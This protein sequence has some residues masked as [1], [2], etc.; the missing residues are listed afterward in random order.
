MGRISKAITLKHQANLGEEIEE[1]EFSEGDEI[2]V[3]KEWAESFLCK[4]AEG[5]LFNIPKEFV[6]G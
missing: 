4:N 1:V 3:L 6:D 2:T 5:Q